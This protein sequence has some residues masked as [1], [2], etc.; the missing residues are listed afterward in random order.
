MKR[1]DVKFFFALRNEEFE[2]IFYSFNFPFNV[3]HVLSKINNALL[4]FKIILKE[5]N[6]R[7]DTKK[8]KCFKSFLKCNVID[9]ILFLIFVYVS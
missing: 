4:D 9:H 2:L 6:V 1:I 7:L 3:D 5:I 8:K